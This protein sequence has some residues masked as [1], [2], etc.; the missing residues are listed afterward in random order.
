MPE[1]IDA[2]EFG[3]GLGLWNQREQLLREDSR[4]PRVSGIPIQSEVEEE[5]LYP[6]S[7]RLLPSQSPY[8]QPHPLTSFQLRQILKPTNL[9][10]GNNFRHSFYRGGNL[11]KNETNGIYLPTSS[12]TL[13]INSSN[14]IR[15][16]RPISFPLT[17]SPSNSNNTLANFTQQT[18]NV[19]ETNAQGVS[20]SSQ[21][22]RNLQQ[23]LRHIQPQP[24]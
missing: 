2:A 3:V 19:I 23:Q 11:F 12:A 24:R 8:V 10:V 9:E 6:V 5:C 1:L 13:P 22:L 15:V 17:T 16:T 21:N 4:L 7:P 18:V 14:L 20:N